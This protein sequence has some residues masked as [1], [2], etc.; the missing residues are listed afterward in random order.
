MKNLSKLLMLVAVMV[1]AVSCTNDVQPSATVVETGTVNNTRGGAAEA[2]TEVTTFNFNGTAIDLSKLEE[3]NL[4]M[5]EAAESEDAAALSN[6]QNSLMSADKEA[7]LLDVKF[8]MSEEPVDNGLF[9]F[10]IET[11]EQKDLTIQMYDEEGFQLAAHN[12]FQVNKGENYKALNV[13]SLENGSY[14]FRL[15]DKEGKELSRSVNIAN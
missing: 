4:T 10:S 14:T 3:L 9:V 15:T 13:N 8:S 12:Q 2:I 1:A 5:M 11:E 7:Q 6:V